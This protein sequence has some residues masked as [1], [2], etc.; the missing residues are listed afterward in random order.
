MDSIMG[1]DASKFQRL[2]E[3][4]MEGVKSATSKSD[5]NRILGVYFLKINGIRD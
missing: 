1:I 2:A 3:E 5:E 4:C